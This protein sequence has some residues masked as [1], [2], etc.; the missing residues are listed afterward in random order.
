ML[1]FLYSIIIYPLYQLVELI[2]FVG[3]KVFKNSGYALF[4]VSF[5][6]S[7]LCLPLYI[8]A[9]QWQETER[10]IQSKL[11]PGIDRIKKA[12]K[13]DEQYMILSTYYKQNHYHPMMALRSSISLAIQIPFFIAAYKF[14]SNLEELRGFSFF[15]FKDLGAPDSL[16]QIGNFNINVLP[17]A[18]TL[19][20]VIAGAIYSK[21][22]P[23]KEKIQIYVTALVFLVLLYN[24]P[25][26]LVIYWTMNNLFSL[27]KNIFY[28]MKHPI[29]VLYGCL[30][31]F[32]LCADWYLIFRH[33][34]FLYRRLMLI[35]ALSIVFFAPLLVKFIN[36][37]IQKPL[38]FL[39]D[40]KSER[41]QLFI[42]SGIA[43]A[44]L[45]GTTLPSYVISSSPMEFSFVDK[46]NSP[47]FFLRHSLWQA[48]GFCVFWPCCIYFMF[49]KKTQTLLTLFGTFF[50]TGAVI[51]AFAFGGDYGTLSNLITFSDAGALKPSTG[52]A[53]INLSILLIPVV[54]I[55]VLLLFK[56]I[57]WLSAICSVLI[58]AFTGITV[59]HSF[60]ISKS[61]KQL[62]E[63]KKNNTQVSSDTSITP[64]FN[65][66]KTNEN[67]FIIMLDRAVNGF[68]PY[69]FEESPDLFEKYDGFTY[70]PNTVSYADHT[71][72]GAPPMYGG[73]DYTP[74]E[75][76]ER[77][78]E[79]L[80]SKHNESITALASIFNNEGFS[81]TLTDMSWAN[82]SWIPDTR[83]YNDYP[84]INVQPTIRVYTDV[85]LKRH[86][87]ASSTTARSDL[88][89]RNFIWFS[90]LKVMPLYF[91][92]SIYND[93]FWWNT[94]QTLGNLQDVVNNYAVLDF[95]PE[96]TSFDSDKPSFTYLVN[97]L[98]HEPNYLQAPDYIPLSE[99]TDKG[100]GI[101]AED[102]HY[103]ANAGALKRLGEFFEYLKENDIYD[104]TKIIITADHGAP[105]DN[106]I[107]PDQGK[108]NLP[109]RI[110]AYNPILLVK[111]FNSH[112]SLKTDNSF[113]T[114]AD[115]PS[116]ALKDI[117]DEAINPFTGNRI[118]RPEEKEKV[119]VPYVDTWS[120]DAHNK[121][122][123]KIPGDNWFSVHDNIFDPDNWK[124]ESPYDSK[125]AK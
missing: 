27:V 114:N 110:E 23:V 31:F 69:I 61:Y 84:Y 107:S 39:A 12:F 30:C 95:L 8:I 120:P 21:G 115:T 43:L 86:P 52:T 1:D 35:S 102:V 65:L 119:Y 83:I 15:I 76:N 113:M 11:K 91:R 29:W 88:L 2:Y 67:V 56:R 46:Y 121:N 62:K 103:H 4:I 45:I 125:E 104:N 73:Y 19:I 81:V 77:S 18:M 105:L 90:F 112:G 75:M 50:C 89:K 9:E 122:T 109:F 10:Q 34:G 42:I 36:Y 94:N 100:S 123:F 82:Y 6:V 33:T 66:S 25:S 85:W 70:Y 64:I 117:D 106:Y 78:D 17:I 60:T 57:K 7:F 44:V 124:Q 3:W 53:I 79:S 47:F 58:I 118:N 22:H 116:L 63:L 92:D 59:V 49:G 55:I 68:V 40:N 20:N 80:V 14:L 28:K 93:G 37:L 41:T 111:D 16:F 54:L 98:T 101:F 38:R 13:G 99:V 5:G 24:S 96:L 51:N 32:V 26:G 108:A 71:L 97:E 72:I 48:I 87:E 74:Y